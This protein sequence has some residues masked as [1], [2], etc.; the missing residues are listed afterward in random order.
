[1]PQPSPR[2]APSGIRIETRGEFGYV[3]DGEDVRQ[4]TVDD[5]EQ[6]MW[7]DR[8]G[9]ADIRSNTIR[10][11]DERPVIEAFLKFISKDDIVH[12]MVLLLLEEDI[13]EPAELVASR[14]GIPVQ[15]VYVARKRHER[16]CRQF[17]Q[18]GRNK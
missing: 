18:E 1:L 6:S 16:L 13:D 10:N 7:S 11:L 5:Y 8:R 4:L 9:A 14:V 17:A 3:E 12:R 15:E 2:F